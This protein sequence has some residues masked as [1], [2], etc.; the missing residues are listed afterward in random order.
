MHSQEW[1]NRESSTIFCENFLLIFTMTGLVYSFSRYVKVFLFSITLTK[2]ILRYKSYN[3]FFLMVLLKSF[4]F[5]FTIC[6]ELLMYPLNPSDPLI[7]FSAPISW[8]K[9][10]DFLCALSSYF[11]RYRSYLNNITKYFQK[12]TNWYKIWGWEIN[13]LQKFLFQCMR[14]WVSNMH[15]KCQEQLDKPIILV[16]RDRDMKT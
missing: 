10:H 13:Q 8:L 7:N 12:Y 16:F 5:F 6:H 14:F 9:C 15:I 2:I 3:W 11:S 4:F 1:Y